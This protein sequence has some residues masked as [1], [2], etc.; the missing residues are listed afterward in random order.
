[1]QMRRNELLRIVIIAGA[2]L[3]VVSLA[4]LF[5]KWVFS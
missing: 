2:A 4:T 5:F 3:A 1:M